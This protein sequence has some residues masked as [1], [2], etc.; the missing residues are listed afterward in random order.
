MKKLRA[1]ILSFVLPAVHASGVRAQQTADPFASGSPP[2]RAASTPDPFVKGTPSPVAVKEEADNG[3][4]EGLVRIEYFSLPTSAARKVIRDFPKQADLYHWLGA[5]LEKEKTEVKLERLSAL[6]V[7][8]GQRAK[9]EEI[10][11]VP[12]PTEF[13]PPQ[14]EE[15]KTPAPS[16]APPAAPT[17]APTPVPGPAKGAQGAPG[18]PGPAAADP[19]NSVQPAGDINKTATPSAFT[20]RNTGWTFEMELTIRDDGKTVDLN[21]A[22]EHVKFTGMLPQTAKGDSYQ[23][24][25]ESGKLTCQILT[26]A[27]RPTL[28]GTLSPPVNTGAPDGNTADRTWFLFLTVNRTR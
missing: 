25:F 1:L 14:T 8:S 5:E 13:E 23:P 4:R 15:S 9:L 6:K 18:Y 24:G 3:L 20:F 27:G 7:R 19:N 10:E 26:V 2:P 16:P 21:L 17:P 12:Y 11:E 22:P 28:A